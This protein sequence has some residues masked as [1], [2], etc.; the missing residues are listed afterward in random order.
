MERPD[1]ALAHI[2]SAMQLDPLSLVINCLKG[3]VLYFARRYDD[4][5]HQLLNTIEMDQN[6]LVTRYFLGVVY[7]RTGRFEESVVQFEKAK[8]TSNNHPGP[9]AGLS[10][11]LALSGKKS[12]ARKI[13]EALQKLTARRYVAPY[14]I[15]MAHLALG[16]VAKAFDWLEKAFEEHS[17]YL[18]NIKADPGL[19]SLRSD[20]RFLK[21]VRRVGLSG[22]VHSATGKAR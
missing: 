21:L 10:A 22:G 7:L 1:E 8:Q 12:E 19:D 4:A 17:T 2:Q 20:P 15:A 6:F 5:I 9:V 11:A 13:L 14:Y 3:W 18:S 16:D